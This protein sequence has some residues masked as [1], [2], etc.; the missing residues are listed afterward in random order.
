ML[1]TKQTEERSSKGK[2]VQRKS[3]IYL[4]QYEISRVLRHYYTESDTDSVVNKLLKILKNSV[5][6]FS[7]DDLE[8]LATALL[9]DQENIA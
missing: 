4:L 6:N 2:A 3:G 8:R 9:Q 5:D 1:V 7:Y